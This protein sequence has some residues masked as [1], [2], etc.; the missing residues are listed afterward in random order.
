MNKTA[1]ILVLLGAV[2]PLAAF[3]VSPD[4]PASTNSGSSTDKLQSL[5]AD[6]VVAKGKGVEV[7]RNELDSAVVSARANAA[8]RQVAA[9]PDLEQQIL[10]ELVI[11]QLVLSRATDA[12]RAQ[13]KKDFDT[14]LAA[15]KASRGWTDEEFDKAISS[16]LMG[17]TRQQWEK[18]RIDGLTAQIALER[19]MGIKITDEDARKFYDDPA[20]ISKLEQPEMVRVSHILLMT[21]DPQTH[22]PLSD[23]K[24]A[25][26]RK[27]MEDLLKRARAGEDFAKLADQY[28]EDPGVKENHGEYKFSRRDPFVPEFKETAFSLTNVGQVSD[29]ITSQYGYHIIKLSEKIPAKKVDF[30]KVKDQIKDALTQDAV[31]KQIR[32]YVAKLE[33]DADIK[34][35]DDNLKGTD[36]LPPAPE[37]EAATPGAPAPAKK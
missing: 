15:L 4:Q 16:Q 11:N 21:S 18:E 2:A 27:Q 30:D 3:G 7:K 14:R 28:S 1:K 37:T 32:T 9:P 24:K 36:L 25:E 20:N 19:E 31:N 26:K 8:A 35:L 22:E 5:F 29:I 33:K 6:S 23:A 34:I 13:A 17:Q 12:D 10:R